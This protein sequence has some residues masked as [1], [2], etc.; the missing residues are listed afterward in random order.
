[1]RDVFL[2]LT[3]LTQSDWFKNLPDGPYYAGKV[4][5]GY[6]GAI[7]YGTTLEIRE[8]TV[9]VANAALLQD[10]N[11][12]ISS[13]IFPD[14]IRYLGEYS[15]SGVG[16]EEVTVKKEWQYFKGAFIHCNALKK[17]TLEEGVTTISTSAFAGCKALC[18]IDFSETLV[19]IENSAFMECASLA[20][21][22]MPESLRTIGERAFFESGLSSVELNDGLSYVK[23]GAFGDCESLTTLF[24]P[25]SV[26][27]ICEYAFGYVGYF[28]NMKRNDSFTLYVE[29]DSEAL[30]YAEDNGIKHEIMKLY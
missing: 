18:R 14:S 9:S 19:T 5:I 11:E 10:G 7:P 17:V 4:L 13:V 22:K 2:N 24:V 21:I 1:M 16:F 23:A 27:T 25:K 8:G 20:D 28:S 6:K 12:N 30:R 15:L 3:A 26:D 29:E